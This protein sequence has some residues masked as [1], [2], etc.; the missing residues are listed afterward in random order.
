MAIGTFTRSGYAWQQTSAPTD[1]STRY[2]EEVSFDE[3]RRE[4]RGDG[5]G[6][7]VRLETTAFTNLMAPSEVIT[8]YGTVSTTIHAADQYAPEGA[9]TASIVSFAAT[10][11]AYLYTNITTAASDRVRV[12]V[13]AKLKNPGSGNVRLRIRNRASAFV[14][15]PNFAIT[16]DYRRIE[17]VF[18][19]GAGAT[20]VRAGALNQVSGAAQDLVLWGFQ[21]VVESGASLARGNSYV[22]TTGAA[23]SLAPEFLSYTGTPDSFRT[24]GYWVQHR[25]FMSS[26]EM[27]AAST[28][29]DQNWILVCHSS[30]NH[31]LQLVR[32]SG[33]MYVRAVSSGQKVISSAVTFSA[34]QNLSIGI[35]PLAGRLTL[36]GFTTGDGAYTGTSFEFPAGDV[37]IGG[38][39][40]GTALGSGGWYYPYLVGV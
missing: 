22:R 30:L 15:S 9:T 14:D 5:Y 16:G 23:A 31:Y 6:E 8:G 11:G 38:R 7:M 26:A 17:Y 18:D 4:D 21:A 33:V 12:S 19:V 28:S 1:G 27:L 29:G 10:S 25:P 40:S 35:E 37:S 39:L 3:L 2:L 24:S 36:R 34:E 32:L 20:T 13:F